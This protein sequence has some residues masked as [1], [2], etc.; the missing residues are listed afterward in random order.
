MCLKQGYTDVFPEA[1]HICNFIYLFAYLFV[2][3]LTKLWIKYACMT[4]LIS[5]TRGRKD[6][7]DLYV[8]YFFVSL[9]T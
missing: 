3:V 6:L 7:T 2:L 8:C 5:I 9:Q 4:T 1:H